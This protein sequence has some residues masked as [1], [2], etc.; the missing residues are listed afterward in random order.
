MQAL[1]AEIVE[2]RRLYSDS[3]NEG[4]WTFGAEIGP[5]VLDSHLLPAVLRCIDAANAEL[6][7]Q[8]L[9]RWAEINA[10]GAVWQK[11]MHGRSTRWDASMGPVVDMQEMMSL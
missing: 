5:T 1:F 3:K 2:Y 7:P 9:Q 10:K 6:V 4:D 11:V 8:E